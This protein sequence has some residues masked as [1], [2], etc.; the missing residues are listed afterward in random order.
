MKPMLCYGMRSRGIPP[1]PEPRGDARTEV[2]TLFTTSK[3]E[4]RLRL[5]FE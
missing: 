1:I 5:S 2:G 4:E 3:M